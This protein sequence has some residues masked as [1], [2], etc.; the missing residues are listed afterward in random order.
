MTI[1]GIVTGRAV[2]EVPAEF[3]EIDVERM[4]PAAVLCSIVATLCVPLAP[5]GARPPGPNRQERSMTEARAYT[6]A[7]AML[8][9]QATV[10]ARVRHP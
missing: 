10:G 5:P 6:D 2:Y 4:H 8:H 1:V 9:S 7:V 3:L